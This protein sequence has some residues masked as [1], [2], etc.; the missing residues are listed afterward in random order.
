MRGALARGSQSAPRLAL[1]D[2]VGPART[3][4]PR[5]GAAQRVGERLGEVAVSRG[6]Q[7]G[8]VAAEVHEMDTVAEPGAREPLEHRLATGVGLHDDVNALEALDVH[9]VAI[10]LPLVGAGDAERLHVV[11]P[12]GVQSDSPSTSTTYRW[13][14]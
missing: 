2:L 7:L 11:E 4:R 6:V 9:G 8:D 14:V 10:V 13:S 12:Q 1:R 5:L 3:L